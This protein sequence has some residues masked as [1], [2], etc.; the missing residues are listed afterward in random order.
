[1]TNKKITKAKL[2]SYLLV[3]SLTTRTVTKT[4]KEI[5]EDLECKTQDVQWWINVLMIDKQIKVWEE[6]DVRH[7]SVFC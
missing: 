1:M 5:A 4:N 2:I 3:N 7:I 6:D